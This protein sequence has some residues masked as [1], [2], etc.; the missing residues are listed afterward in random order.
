M[1]DS[2]IADDNIEKQF[3]RETLSLSFSLLRAEHPTLAL[4]VQNKL[5]EADAPKKTKNSEYLWLC[6]EAQQTADIITALS[7]IGEH[8]AQSSKHSQEELITIRSLLLDWLF[9]AQSSLE[10]IQLGLDSTE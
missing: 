9:F 4:I 8:A 6:L 2:D 10:G 3:P 7:E 1:S 5:Y